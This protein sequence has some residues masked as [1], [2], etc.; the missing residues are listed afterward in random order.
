MM[1]GLDGANPSGVP[2]AAHP[3]REEL[4]ALVR[5]YHRLEGEHERSRAGGSVRRHLEPRLNDARARFEH[6]LVEY[7]PDASTRR[8]WRAFLHHHGG[9][10]AG[11]AAIA[12]VLFKGRSEDG[13]VLEARHD[14]SGELAVAVDGQVVERLEGHGLQIAENHPAVFRLDGTVFRE[15]FDADRAALGALR[16][17]CASGGDP[18]WE[19]AAVL[20][21]DG[22]V[23][24]NFALTARGRRALD[25]TAPG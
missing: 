12:P 22:L 19:H 23:D 24:V 17:F 20:L 9:E 5:H 25:R 13:S 21:A 7:V 15:V 8:A 6:R 10:P 11:P 16:D 14:R 3:C 1:H 2:V 4:E 18:P